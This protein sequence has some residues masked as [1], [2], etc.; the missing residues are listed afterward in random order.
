MNSKEIFIEY[1]DKKI[2]FNNQNYPILKKKIFK[3]NKILIFKN[4]IEVNFI[5]NISKKSF[6]LNYLFY[7]LI[8]NFLTN[9]NIVQSSPFSP[10]I[11]VNNIFISNYEVNEREKLLIALGTS[12]TKAK[13][14]AQEN[15]IN[16][17]LQKLHAKNIGVYVDPNQVDEVLSNFLSVR[18]L[19]IENLSKTLREFGSSLNELKAYLRASVLIRNI[20]NN[21][22]YS[23]MSPDDFDFSLFRPTASIS[24]PSQINI[25]EIINILK[26]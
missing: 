9:S 23:R 19:T 20:I 2:L 18:N 10:A 1:M 17:T 26:L 5:K 4:A 24:I 15:L 21:S 14:I 16:E 11:K 25:S 8:I 22:F 13:K 12:K 3:D 6:I 7:F